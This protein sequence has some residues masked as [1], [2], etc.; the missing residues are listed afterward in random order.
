MA[1]E[2]YISILQYSPHSM[3]YLSGGL[4]ERRISALEAENTAHF[5][6]NWRTLCDLGNGLYLMVRHITRVVEF[7]VLMIRSFPLLQP[8]FQV[9]AEQLK[10]Q[11]SDP[12]ESTAVAD[13]L[14][15]YRHRKALL[16]RE[17]LGMTIVQYAIWASR[18]ASSAVGKAIKS[19]SARP[20]GSGISNDVT[21][22]LHTR[23]IPS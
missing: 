18:M 1:F 9:E 17:D 19:R 3:S 6:L 11:Y 2:R 13:K 23:Q 5:G 10:L 14:R 15:W 12:A 7:A 4:A 20:P 8:H 21:S 22:F 16:Q